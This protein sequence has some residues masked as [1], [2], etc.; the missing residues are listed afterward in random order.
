MGATGTTQDQQTPKQLNSP[1]HNQC[2][3]DNLKREQAWDGWPSILFADEQAIM[4]T[5]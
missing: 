5:S 1:R 2:D 4:K 3:W